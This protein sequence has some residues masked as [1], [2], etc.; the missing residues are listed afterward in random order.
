MA[1]TNSQYDEIMRNY[2]QMRLANRDKLLLRYE[3]VYDKIPELKELEHSI[4]ALSLENARK[5]LSGTENNLIHY[6]EQLHQLSAKRIS[7]LKANGYPDNYLETIYTC[8]DCQDTGYINNHKCR[9]FK[10]AV[11]T[12]LYTQ[13]NLQEILEK[14]NFDTFSFDYYS[15]NHID[16]L[17]GRSSLDM[18]KGAVHTCR[19]FID[20]FSAEFKN[21]IILGNTGVGKTFLSNCIAKE[22]MDRIYSVIYLTATDFFEICRKSSFSRD[23][24]AERINP[25][26]TSCDLLIIDDLGTELSNSLTNSQLFVYLNERILMQKSTLI[27]TNLSLEQIKSTYSERVYS[28]ITSNY[29]ILRLVGDDI[30]IQKKLMN[31]EAN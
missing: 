5:L 3:E 15:A 26:L 11:I 9:C 19:N 28:R 23:Y 8:S 30:R 24:Q 21:L 31:R 18:M 4:S 10:K 29:E 14:E 2:E 6:K 17:T 13:S 1:L 22:L 7:L 12:L 20:T 25:Y 27:S 16:R